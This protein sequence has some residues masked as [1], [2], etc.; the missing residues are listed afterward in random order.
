MARATKA[1]VAGAGGLGALA[2]DAKG[3]HAAPGLANAVQRSHW[4]ELTSPRHLIAMEGL[5]QHALR[6]GMEIRFP[7]MDWDF[8]MFAI[9]V[10]SRL[11]PPPWPFERLHRR[12]LENILPAAV[13][14]RRS[15]AN[16]ADVVA[17]RVRRQLPSIQ[18][19]FDDRSWA[20]SRYVD[21]G[22]ARE[23]LRTFQDPGNLPF[24][25]TWSVWAIATL[26]AWLRRLSS[27]TAGPRRRDAYERPIRELNVPP[28]RLFTRPLVSRPSE[29]CGT[30]S[31]G[32]SK[33]CEN[34]PPGVGRRSGPGRRYLPGVNY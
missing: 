27:Y 20:S 21:Q 3:V 24:G 32:G 1:I 31:P 29:T 9:S 11:W 22:A 18:A 12:A 30:F 34:G 14:Q 8:A 16:A 19:L 7:F 6:N 5:Q 17:N 26:E 15:K 28:V 33:P 25:T 2:A 13:V 23:V 10:P 4:R